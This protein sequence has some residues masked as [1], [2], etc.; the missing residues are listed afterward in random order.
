VTDMAVDSEDNENNEYSEYSEN[1]EDSVDSKRQ[2][3][4]TSS[5]KMRK[6]SQDL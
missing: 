2:E 4:I 6:N 3:E 1:S 5:F